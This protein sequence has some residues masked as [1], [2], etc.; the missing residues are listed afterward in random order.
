MIASVMENYVTYN[1]FFWAMGG[2]IAVVSTLVGYW[3]NQIKSVDTRLETH[4][5]ND[6]KEFADYKLQNQKITNDLQRYVDS[7]NNEME[8]VIVK[9]N[10]NMQYT[11]DAVRRVETHILKSNK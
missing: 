2:G 5:E 4:R 11:A 1:V 6:A 3:I 7:K 8:K 10:E 9:I